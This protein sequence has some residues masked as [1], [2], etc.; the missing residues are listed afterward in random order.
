M[1]REAKLGI[2]VAIVLLVIAACGGSTQSGLFD[3]SDSGTDGSS[4][5]G[6]G[7]TSTDGGK[8]DIASLTTCTKPGACELAAPGCCGINCQGASELIGIRRG[9]SAALKAA[10]CDTSKPAICPDCEARRDPNI[11]AFCESGKCVVVDIRT[12]DLSECSGDDCVLRYAAC[13]QSCTGGSLSEIISVRKG[14]E[15]DLAEQLCTGTEAC[16]KCLPV[17]PPTMRAVCNRQTRH[18]EV[19]K[20]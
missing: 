5:G 4:S 10:T 17:F 12:D 15:E 8:P 20:L 18:C 11:Q 2:A 6:D 14:R 3:Q 9:E 16:P 1:R 13:C 7:S 19:Q